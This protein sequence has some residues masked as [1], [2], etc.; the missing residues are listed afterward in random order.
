MICSGSRA[1]TKP[2]MS[3]P[4]ERTRL[5]VTLRSAQAG[6][7]GIAAP[8]LLTGI[9]AWPNPARDRLT[10]D[11][12]GIPTDRAELRDAQGRLVAT[13]FSGTSITGTYTADISG[14]TTG[15]YMLRLSTEKG[16][17]T[18]RIIVAR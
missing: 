5:G 7:S 3:S 15:T 13:L 17:H 2:S 9:S 8:D 6:S 11:M 4:T 10:I 14:V 18:E 12:H 16:M 1:P